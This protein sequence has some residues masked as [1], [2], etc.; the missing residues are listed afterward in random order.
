MHLAA[1]VSTYFRLG[2]ANI[3]RVAVYT[4]QL[5]S[6]FLA[7]KLIIKPPLSGPFLK[8]GQNS[9]LKTN[10]H[11]D[12]DPCINDSAE[13]PL[14]HT[15][16]LF[17]HV[18]L[19]LSS[20]PNWHQSVL[21]QAVIADN[22]QHW[23]KLS[24]FSLN[25][26]DV[27]GVWEP[28][29][30]TW[31]LLFV[32]NYLVTQNSDYID[33]ANQWIEDWSTHNP[34]NE[35]VNWKCAQEA[36]FRMLHLA[37]AGMMLNNKVPSSASAQFVEQH[38]DRIL[39]TLSYAKAQDNNHGTSEAAALV[40]AALW[41][42]QCSAD[43]K[44]K[45][46]E[47]KARR[48]L[49]E[50][51]AR[52]I[53]PDGSF[54]QYSVTYHRLMLDTM[55]L[56]ELFCRFV[57]QSAF[58]SDSYQQLQLAAIW[59]FEMTDSVSGD[60]PNLGANDGAHILNYFNASYRNFFYSTELACLLFCNKT[61]VGGAIQRQVQQRFGLNAQAQMKR[62]NTSLFASGAY[63]LCR[64]LDATNTWAMLRVPKFQFRPSQA[65]TLHLDLW[66]GGENILRD[67]GSFSYNTEP[68]WLDYFSG[69]ASHNVV[70]F[71]GLPQM[72]KISR[73]LFANWPR[74]TAFSC[75]SDSSKPDHHKMQA[76]FVLWHG[77]VHK[78]EILLN[79]S[80]VQIVDTVS[81][82]KQRATL[83]WR[84]V[85]RNWQQQ[86]NTV[87]CSDYKIT[88]SATCDITKFALLEGYESRYYGIKSAL[89]VLEAEVSQDTQ[90]TTIISWN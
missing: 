39:P 50:R 70:E 30:F 81:G 42:Q 16:T 20:V 25:I 69:S 19:R 54:S 32:E 80:K 34:L 11:T 15:V 17:G 1:K 7:R 43:S 6:G 10:T 3:A 67:G 47:Q 29:R 2:F 12:S 72:Q 14:Q 84:L 4:L 87:Y 22:Q 44:W 82:V 51:L 55:C 5:K 27:K 31:L 18:T 48:Y 89:P 79:R 56:V 88:L 46:L 24:D 61:A 13:K 58:S 59:L 52:L 38:V 90:I 33:I 75:L 35:G 23:S 74:Y 8:V 40:I 41:M 83:R 66:R 49:Q 65:D 36:S 28:S 76:S 78:R 73:F 9:K 53:M 37:A 26:G 71:D 68:Q 63:A 57:G 64:N 77:A 21:T 85:K 86:H 60:A 45:K 62:N